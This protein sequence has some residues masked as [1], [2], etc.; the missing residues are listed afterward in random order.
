YECFFLFFMI[1][2][3][4]QA[5]N[6]TVEGD[7]LCVKANKDNVEYWVSKD[8]IS[9]VNKYKWYENNGAMQCTTIDMRLARYIMSGYTTVPPN[10]EVH[11]K[12][13][14]RYDYTRSNLELVS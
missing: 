1:T 6:P 9:R 7:A 12:N 4:M 2:S 5:T 13:G 10:K 11:H 8:D 3:K 14:N